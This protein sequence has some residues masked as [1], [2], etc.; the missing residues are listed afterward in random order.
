MALNDLK[1][2]VHAGGYDT[3]L[4]KR[5]ERIALQSGL[6]AKQDAQRA[7]LQA[8]VDRFRA[9]A[10]KARQAQ[11]RIKMLEKMQDISIPLEDRATPFH[12]DEPSEL[13]S[14]L[15]VLDDA[16]LGYV[17]GQAGAEERVL[18]PGSRRPH[19]HHRPER[20]G[21]DDARKINRRAA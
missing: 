1:L 3:Y 15:I 2:E 9:K 5:A 18:P 21:Q 8:F 12:F 16:D 10:S 6:K 4:R 11:S 19:R 7:H 13:A 17:A 20:A 14:P